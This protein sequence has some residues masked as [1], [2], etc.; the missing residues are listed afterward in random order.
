MRSTVANAC[1]IDRVIGSRLREERISRRLDEATFAQRIGVTPETLEA[2]EM[3]L[4]RID[5]HTMVAIHRQLNVDPRHFFAPWIDK[6]SP[7][8]TALDVAAV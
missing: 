8:D 1:I 6:R 5:A 2:F 7:P 4:T 3:G